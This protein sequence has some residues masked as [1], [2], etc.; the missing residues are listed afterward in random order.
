M[1]TKS[2][3][4]YLAVNAALA[5]CK[6]F[7]FIGSADA[8]SQRT[9]KIDEGTWVMVK[10]IAMRIDEPEAYAAGETYFPEKM[11]EKRYYFPVE[12]GLEIKIK[13]KL[14]KLRQLDEAKRKK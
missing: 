7:W 9:N 1:R 10:I 12:R 3:A 11:G 5:R 8:Y 6:R 14:E 13:E 2:N 4:V